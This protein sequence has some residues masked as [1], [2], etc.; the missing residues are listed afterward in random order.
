[1][2][3]ENDSP[4]FLRQ[5]GDA[6]PVGSTKLN[7]PP[8]KNKFLTELREFTEH[9]HRGRDAAVIFRER[10][11]LHSHHALLKLVYIYFIEQCNQMEIF[12]SPVKIVSTLVQENKWTTNAEQ[13]L[14]RPAPHTADCLAAQNCISDC[15]F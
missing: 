12:H 4:D 10:R 11:W 1:M 8:L 13:K 5:C 14:K 15:V 2:D 6:G 9:K 3:H 7:G